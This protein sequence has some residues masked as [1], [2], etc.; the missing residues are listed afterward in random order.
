MKKFV[1]A[2]TIGDWALRRRNEW[3]IMLAERQKISNRQAG[4]RPPEGLRKRSESL[5]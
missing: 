1:N 2:V 4:M 5:D 3:K